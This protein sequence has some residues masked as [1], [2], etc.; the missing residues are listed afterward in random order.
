MAEIIDVNA[1]KIY[2]PSGAAD[3][4][5]KSSTLNLS[6]DEQTSPTSKLGKIHAL[7]NDQGYVDVGVSDLALLETVW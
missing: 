5:L 3:V 2:Q 7:V 1:P 4:F 6:V